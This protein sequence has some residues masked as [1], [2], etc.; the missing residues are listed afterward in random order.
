MPSSYF[1]N[2]S[3]IRVVPIAFPD[4]PCF[5]RLPYNECDLSRFGA[6]DDLQVSAIS[7]VFLVLSIPIYYLFNENT[8]EGKTL[9]LI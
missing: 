1:A 3:P 5:L 7:I 6:F 4:T 8:E 2:W 9:E